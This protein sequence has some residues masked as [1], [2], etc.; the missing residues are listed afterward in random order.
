MIIMNEQSVAIPESIYDQLLLPEAEG[1]LTIMNSQSV[2][3]NVG[4][5]QIFHFTA[6]P[7]IP[8]QALLVSFAVL[9]QGGPHKH[10]NFFQLSDRV[11]FSIYCSEPN[12]RFAF[13]VPGHPP[14]KTTR[15]GGGIQT[16]WLL[17]DNQGKANAGQ[18]VWFP[19]PTH[20]NEVSFGLSV[21]VARP[22]TNIVARF[23]PT[24]G[25]P[26]KY[27]KNISIS[28]GPLELW[29]QKLR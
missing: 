6:V 26:G 27:L 29:H 19:E 3:H 8:R 25:E 11:Y 7:A 28:W 24:N 10:A 12:S 5:D 18:V 17:M 16:V 14:V 15:P 9:R 20:F 2:V 4:A 13:N 1:E 23:F 21:M 22:N